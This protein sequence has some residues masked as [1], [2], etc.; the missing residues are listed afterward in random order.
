MKQ[1]FLKQFLF[2]VFMLLSLMAHAQNSAITPPKAIKELFSNPQKRKASIAKDEISSD[3]LRWIWGD[4][5]YSFIGTSTKERSLR[6]MVLEHEIHLPY[7]HH[8]INSWFYK[9]NHLQTL[10]TQE[11]LFLFLILCQLHEYQNIFDKL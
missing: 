7:L 6:I 5:R 11:N 10:S 3:G 9:L 2:V 1:F 4:Y 8:K